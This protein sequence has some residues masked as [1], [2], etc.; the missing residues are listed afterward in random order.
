MK[1]RI[2][3]GLYT[4]IIKIHRHGTSHGITVPVDALRTLKWKL[5]DELVVSMLDDGLVINLN[6]SGR[7]GRPKK[8]FSKPRA[9]KLEQ[10]WKTER[11]T[12][13]EQ[14][15]R[16]RLE[17]MRSPDNPGR[18]RRSTLAAIKAAEIELQDLEAASAARRAKNAAEDSTDE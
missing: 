3:N 9:G 2:R 5:G 18:K 13:R 1:P 15:V 8:D 14:A 4:Y 16:E 17:W 7:V 12:I 10:A 11:E 6:K